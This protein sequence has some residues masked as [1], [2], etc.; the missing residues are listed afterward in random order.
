M[1][2]PTRDQQ[3]TMLTALRATIRQLHPT[4]TAAHLETS[5]QNVGY[6]FWL[7]DIVLADGTL[8]ATSDPDALR[9]THDAVETYLDLDWDDLVGE[10][11]HG[12]A[13]LTLPA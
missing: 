6:G 10:D 9:R 5:D 3:R 8:L 4:A 2:A 7:T 12:R 1:T 11:R 13:T